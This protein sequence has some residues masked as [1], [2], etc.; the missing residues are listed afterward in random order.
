[1]TTI[2]ESRLVRRPL[3]EAFALVSDFSTAALWD[4]GVRSSVQTSIGKATVGT[5]YEVVAVVMGVAVPMRYRIETLLPNDRLVLEG[6]SAS[7]TARD[8]I[9]FTSSAAGTRIEWTLTLTF[10]GPSRLLAPFAGPMVRRIGVV[11]LDGLA[12]WLD[13]KLAHKS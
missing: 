6:T 11:A 9:R 12:A 8:D 10:H 13:G 5:R 1:M 4:P 3:D 7:S 2:T